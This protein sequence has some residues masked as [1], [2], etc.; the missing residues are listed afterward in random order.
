MLFPTTYAI[1]TLLSSALA[2]S[3]PQ[4]NKALVGRAATS[5]SP[6]TVTV[7][8]TA[9]DCS[10]DRS[11]ATVQSTA[12]VSSQT[13]ST[14]TAARPTGSGC[15]LEYTHVEAGVYEQWLTFDCYMN[16]QDFGSL[17]WKAMKS[18]NDF[19]SLHGAQPLI[20]N[21]TLAVAAQRWGDRCQFKHSGGVLG[22]FGENLAVSSSDSI[23]IEWT[24]SLN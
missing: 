11:P 10:L 12:K 7:T 16:F 9:S 1:A 19:R 14:S 15:K 24:R 4:N 20:W 8:V 2:A 18:H 21:Q 23:D 17:Q 3:L 22:P 5:S 13:T 6:A